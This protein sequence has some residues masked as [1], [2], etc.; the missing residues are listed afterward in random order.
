MYK[1]SHKEFITALED[2]TL[3]EEMFTH[4]GHLRAAWIYLCEYEPQQAT[5]KCCEAIKAYAD[6]LGATDKFN[7]TISIALMKI[8]SN[9][10]ITKDLKDSSAAVGQSEGYDWENFKLHNKDFFENALAILFRYYDKEVLFSDRAKREFI[11]P[12]L[13]FNSQ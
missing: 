13:A 12:T 3:P 2:K 1:Y 8:I 4:E 9:R 5:K 7:L 10:L 11:Q 6:S